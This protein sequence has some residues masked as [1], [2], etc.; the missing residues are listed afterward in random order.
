M[1][2]SL[3]KVEQLSGT[4]VTSVDHHFV[5]NV[6]N[7]EDEKSC[8][9]VTSSVQHCFHEAAPNGGALQCFSAHCCHF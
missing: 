2:V 1:M 6:S 7:F 4:T 5:E 8:S 9:V 3:V